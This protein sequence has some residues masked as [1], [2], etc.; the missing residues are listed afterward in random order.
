MVSS[1]HKINKI[2]KNLMMIGRR[3][4]VPMSAYRNGGSEASLSPGMLSAGVY[5]SDRCLLE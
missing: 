5:A 2:R 3:R 4:R 1:N